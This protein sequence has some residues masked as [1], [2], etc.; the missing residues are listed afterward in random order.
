ML[1]DAPIVA[2]PKDQYFTP[3]WIIAAARVAFGGAIDLDPASCAEANRIVQARRFIAP[4]DDGLLTEWTG[5]VWINPPFS[6]KQT[7]A[8]VDKALASDCRWIMLTM[9]VNNSRWMKRLWNSDTCCVWLLSVAVL[10]SRP[11]RIK[12][13]AKDIKAH[14]K[15]GYTVV[16]WSNLPRSDM[17]CGFGQYGRVR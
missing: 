13:R 12:V 4:P 3:H 8:F 14:A 2:N 9:L 15:I 5:N 17:E 10:F 6:K 1:L 16:I 7:E 11:G